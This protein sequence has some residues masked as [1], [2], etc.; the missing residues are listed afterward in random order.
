MWF[1]LAAG[2]GNAKA[3]KYRDRV[4]EN[5]TASQIAEA[6]RLVLEPKPKGQY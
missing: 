2:R 3:R 5:M 4:A 6:K 1:D